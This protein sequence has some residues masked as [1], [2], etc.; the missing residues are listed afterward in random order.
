MKVAVICTGNICRSP[1]GEILLRE[2]I[3]DI[4]DMAQRVEVTSAGTANWHIDKPMDPRAAAALQRAGL[5]TDATLGAFASAE[6]L[7]EFGLVLVMTR[8]HRT[9]VLARHPEADV[10]L[11]RELLGHGSMDVADPY[12]GRDEDFDTCLAMLREVTPLVVREIRR[13]LADPAV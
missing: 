6:L 5:P 3:A 2:A 7:R 1:M 10:L 8:E 12:F 13:R 11:V 4:P 9:D